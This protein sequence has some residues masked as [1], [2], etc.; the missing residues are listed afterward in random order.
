MQPVSFNQPPHFSA[1]RIRRLTHRKPQEPQTS[2][3]PCI[4]IK[5]IIWDTL[6]C[7]VSKM[8]A[9][10]LFYK[11]IDDS[12]YEDERDPGYSI[13][14]PSKDYNLNVWHFKHIYDD[15][16][17]MAPYSPYHMS[18]KNVKKPAQAEH[19]FKKVIVIGQKWRKIHWQ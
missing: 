15:R 13:K 10:V 12:V 16:S 19:H 8:N 7:L 5:N 2:M 9:S 3:A 17:P 14:K 18:K 1:W 6:K 4:N 11:G